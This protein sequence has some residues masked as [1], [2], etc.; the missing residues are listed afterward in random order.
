MAAV[1]LCR[2]APPALLHST[3]HA[4]LPIARGNRVPVCCHHICSAKNAIY[5][6]RVPFRFNRRRM[7]L[8]VPRSTGSSS[9]EGNP[10]EGKSSGKNKAPFG[11]TRKDVLLIGLGVTLA[12]VGLK[13]G[14]EFVG[15]DSL[16]AGNVVQLF[17][18]LG[19][20][21]GW[22]STYMFRVA[23]KDMTYAQQLRDYEKKVMEKRLE[24]LTEAEL[25][26]L[27]EQVEEE[28]TRLMRGE[29]IN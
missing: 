15:V 9:S 21:I 29:Q 17:I 28:K 27:L 3:A 2:S 16:Q 8:F 18:V 19:L 12:G 10:D 13:S 23:N 24:G 25:E 4:R 1:D 7:I 20:T 11:Y 14:L 22:V 6:G 5:S 26:A